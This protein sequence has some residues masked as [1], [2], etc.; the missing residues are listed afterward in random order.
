MNQE[1][2]T[3]VLK[4]IVDG[5][6]EVF[7]SAIAGSADPEQSKIA[8]GAAG[9]ITSAVATDIKVRAALPKLI[10]AEAKLINQPA[11]QALPA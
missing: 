11:P 7:D 1:I 2:K 4:R 6:E 8:L 3:P 10:A 5:L 9:R